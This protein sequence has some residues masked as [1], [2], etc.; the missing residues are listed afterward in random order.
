MR[1]IIAILLFS[2][3][4]ISC[5]QE[6]YMPEPYGEKIP[7]EE[8]QKESLD[9]VLTGSTSN[10]FKLALEGSSVGTKL[11]GEWKDFPLTFLV[12]SDAAFQE[13]G[14]TED[15]I[16]AMEASDL[17]SI[18]LYH[19]LAQKVDTT[20]LK[21]TYFNVRMPTQLKN[22]RIKTQQYAADI[23]TYMHY[24]AIRDRKIIINGKMVGDYRMQQAIEGDVVLIETFLKKPEKTIWQ[25]MEADERLSMFM[26]IVKSNDDLYGQS[27]YY[28]EEPWGT[29]AMEEGVVKNQLDI[30]SEGQD[31][32]LSTSTSVFAPTNEAFIRAGYQTAAEF[33]Q[34]ND[35]HWRYRGSFVTF[36]EGA[37]YN[38][39][40]FHKT[41]SVLSYH[42][43]W[44]KR[45]FP[46]DISRLNPTVF[47]S[48]DLDDAYLDRYILSPEGYSPEA[49]PEIYCPY[50]FSM[51]NGQLK[52]RLKNAKEQTEA[53]TVIEQDILTLNGP[54]YI[55]DRLFIPNHY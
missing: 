54:L 52:M 47:F 12:P 7:Y 44:G 22:A 30:I 23:Y 16:K 55:V 53:A 2:F 17:D 26:E 34:K 11:T 45:Y 21:A 31:L 39:R 32:I 8:V 51:E 41:D 5:T 1:N 14:Y 48:N 20:N 13:A 18:I 49:Q 50:S 37:A 25:M 29:Y 27:F 35:A 40:T 46:T 36:N 4:F 15:K 3:A 24:I 33:L 6:E 9:A 38:F 42:H 43:G 19:T 28:D 10:L